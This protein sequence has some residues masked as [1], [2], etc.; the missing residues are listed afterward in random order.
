MANAQQESGVV[1]SEH[2]SIDKAKAMWAA[3][4]K[5]DKEAFVN[6]FSDTIRVIMNGVPSEKLKKDYAKNM[7]WWQGVENLTIKD[8]TPAFPDAI[9]Y[10]KE[11]L[12]VQ[13]WLR[14][15]GIHKETGVMI[16]FPFSNLYRFDKDGKI[17]TIVQYF[18][19]ET[20]KDV[21]NSM[22]T[23]ENGTVYINHPY[24][25]AVRKC[26][27]AYCAEDIETMRSF[28]SPKAT[29]WRSDFKAGKTINLEEKL[30]GNKKFFDACD[31]IKL[32]Q[33]GYPDCIY[34]ARDANYLVYSW[35]NMSFTTKDGKEKKDIALLL[36]SGFDKDG[37]INMESIYPG[38][39]FFE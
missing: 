12:W 38:S 8:D 31:N 33:V 17:N 35:W 26:I 13:D 2:E 39:N 32:Q 16:D 15:T 36:I 27:N 25:V 19:P 30:E 23:I 9:Q 21:N 7:D 3:F 18:N 11:G 22:R 28:Y 5:G 24:I 34:Y 1:Y 29:F 37:K 6:F 4:V 10:R 20:F 14:A